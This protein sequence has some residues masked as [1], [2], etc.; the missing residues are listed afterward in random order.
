M[1]T[2][3]PADAHDFPAIAD[4]TNI[5]ITGTAVHFGYQPATPDELRAAWESTRDRYPFLVA[6]LDGVFAGFAKAYQWRS[7]EAYQWTAETGIYVTSA[8]H[9]KGV[10]REL[11]A[12]LLKRLRTAGFHSA[13]GGV[14]LPNPAS[15]RLHQSLGFVHVG[16]VKQAGF[17]LDAWH[18]VAFFQKMLVDG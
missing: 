3:R 8:A 1:L 6:E 10:G 16:T 9:G 4:L 7:R 14:T 2:I 17:K 18:D 11:Y 15:L 13:I 12:L 5:Y